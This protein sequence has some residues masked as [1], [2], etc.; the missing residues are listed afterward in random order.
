MTHPA[1]AAGHTAVITGAASGLGLAAARALAAHGMAVAMIDLPGPRLE[2]AAASLPG[3]VAIPLDVSDAPGVAAAAATVAAGMPPVTFL[4]NNA[5]LS[6]P[7]SALADRAAWDRTLG[8][9]FGGILGVAQAFVPAMLAHGLPGAV[10]NTG[11]KQGITLPPGNPAYN[12]S[13][14]AV[15]AYSEL[16]AHELRSLPGSRVTAHLMI[17]GW[18]HTAMT[19]AEGTAKPAGAWT[20]DEAVAFMLARL[21]AG[22][23]YILCPDNDVT[24]PLDER[25]IAWMAGDLIENR[26]ALSRWHADWAEAFK[27]SIAD[28]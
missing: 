9:N 22:D 18:V 24:R 21:A 27:R 1:I 5:G 20:P 7:S 28:L 25:R 16:L 3:A 2:A 26:P 6:L 14:A 8:V 4:F 15:K 10:I 23:F 19:A 13:K 12:V 11:S 17:P